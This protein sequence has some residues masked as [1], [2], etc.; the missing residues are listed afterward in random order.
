[1]SNKIFINH[2]ANPTIAEPPT[3]GGDYASWLHYQSPFEELV[4]TVTHGLGLIL[5]IG[6][7]AL[8]VTLS[9]ID[10]TIWHV[11]SSSI[12]GTSLVLVFAASTCYHA[13]PYSQA[14]RRLRVAEQALIFVLIAGTYTPFTLVALGSGWGWSLFGVVWILAILGIILNTTRFHRHASVS[15]ALYLGLGWLGLVSIF[16]LK[17]ALAPGGLIW[18]FSGGIAYSVGVVFLSWRK[19]PLNHGIWHVFVLIGSLF[20][21]F[22]VLFYVLPK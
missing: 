20:H 21:Y 4:N 6:G 10:G 3:R 9:G 15:V 11:V 5:S 13:A 8:L 12:Y 14:K 2:S 16:P 22:A 1:M 7:L 19:L 18:L 17:D